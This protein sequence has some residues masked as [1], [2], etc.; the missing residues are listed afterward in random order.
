[1]AYDTPFAGPLPASPP[2]AVV[3]T[4]PSQAAAAASHVVLP[5]HRGVR[6]FP[7]RHYHDLID[8]PSNIYTRFA[9][10]DTSEPNRR[11]G[12]FL[13]AGALAAALVG[14]VIGIVQ[15]GWLS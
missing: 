2:A 1:M 10:N 5:L 13:I 14:A 7:I 12:L 3:S 8:K 4:M 6:S 9:A 11:E 15:N